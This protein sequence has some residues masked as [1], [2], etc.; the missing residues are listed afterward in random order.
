[1]SQCTTPNL[2]VD[3][4][5]GTSY[6]YRRYG[7]AETVP[8]VFMQPSAA[9]STTGIQPS[10]TT[11]RL[12]AKSSCS[13]PAEWVLFQYPHEFAAEVNAFLDE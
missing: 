8:V 1:M 5:S 3:A 11:S 2:T 13:T 4:P 10:S 12:T 7:K 6:A 9:I